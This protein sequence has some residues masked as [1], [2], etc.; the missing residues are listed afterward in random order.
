MAEVEE[1][2]TLAGTAAE[3]EQQWEFD[4]PR[5]RD[6]EQGTPPGESADEWFQTEATRGLATPIGVK[7]N[8]KGVNVVNEEYLEASSQMDAENQSQPPPCQKI[9]AS[10]QPD[11]VEAEQVRAVL[12][13]ITNNT[14]ASMQQVVP[15][16]VFSKK[17]A[18]PKSDAKPKREA[19]EIKKAQPPAQKQQQQQQSA[20]RAKST[21]APEDRGT[22]P[23]RAPAVVPSSNRPATRAMEKNASRT[24]RVTSGTAAA[25]PTRARDPPRVRAPITK[26]AA[27]VKKQQ[28]QQQQKPSQPQITVAKS[29]FL[30]S[31]QRSVTHRQQSKATEELEMEQIVKAKKEAAALRRRNAR[32]VG[33][34]LQGRT[35]APSRPAPKRP[36]TEP[37][38][39][40]NLRTAKRQRV[41]G[42]ETRHHNQPSALSTAA[43]GAPSPWKS[44]AQR[45]AEFTTGVATRQAN[46]RQRLASRGGGQQQRGRAELTVPRTPRFATKSRARAPRFKPTEEAEAA[47]AMAEAQAVKIRQKKDTARAHTAVVP[48][49][50]RRRSERRPLTEFKPFSFATD[51]RAAQRSTKPA[52]EL[53]PFIFGPE[54]NGPV[55]RS[56]AHVVT[57]TA[58][59]AGFAITAVAARS[60]GRGGTTLHHQQHVEYQYENI[61]DE[62]YH[63]RP[64]S[65]NSIEGYNAG[66][67]GAAEASCRRTTAG[68]MLLGGAV[69]V[70]RQEQQQ[71]D[72]NKNTVDDNAACCT[73]ELDGMQAII[74]AGATAGTDR[75]T[76]HNPLYRA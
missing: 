62:Y 2:A 75:T 45:V 5:F 60:T 18:P 8:T 35:A 14:T 51:V 26:K 57:T 48:P 28:K 4:A 39:E 15:G 19:L 27:P 59:S 67:L 61:D 29:P 43:A 3:F 74:R 7:P 31:K 47:K 23:S 22:V 38:K 13:H 40:F 12:A 10:S 32:S 6:F 41:H 42:M 66:A 55:T 34:A 65:G 72:Y 49:A 36:I 58:P 76:L 9:N 33:P 63:Q 37:S 53:P 52:A 11:P 20:P 17:P 54:K 44:T 73:E 25:A 30:R 69:R 46:Q 68:P 24:T 50:A 71:E 56:Q 70:L 16:G 21:V 1:H 64:G